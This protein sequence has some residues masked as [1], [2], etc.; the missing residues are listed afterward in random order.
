MAAPTLEVAILRV[1]IDAT[2]NA[3]KANFDTWLQIF[4]DQVSPTLG[5]NTLN[6]RTVSNWFMPSLITQETIETPV[7]LTNISDMINNVFRI[8]SATLASQTAGRISVAQGDMV[9]AQY[10]LAWP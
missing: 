3:S 8:L 2:N 7:T 1:A 5:R 6:Q 4:G 9:L 10:N